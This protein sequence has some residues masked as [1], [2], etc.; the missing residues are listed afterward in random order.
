MTRSVPIGK[1]Q[2]AAALAV[3]AATSG[4]TTFGTNVNG[5]FR[6]EAPD[7]VCAPSTVIDDEALARIDYTSTDLLSPAGPYQIDEGLPASGVI[8]A[9]AA[10]VSRT[11]PSYTLDVVFP[12]Y[13]DV[14][15]QQHARSSVQTE[16][17]LPG[18]GDAVDA[19][20]ARADRGG[21]A[22]LLAAAESAPSFLAIAPVREP[23]QS[24]VAVAQAEVRPDPVERIKSEVQTTL[25]S[26]RARKQAAS[27]PGIVE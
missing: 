2:V 3:L 13:V 27:F 24:P 7:G 26:S 10:P 9:D 6:C 23:A 18:R 25:A 14:S 19:V 15:G 5:S 12:G 16:V 22:G 11:P 17:F 1:A 8:V 21:P 4:C 20:L